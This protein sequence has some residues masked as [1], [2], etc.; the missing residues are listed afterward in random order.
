MTVAQMHFEFKL[1]LDKIDTFTNPNILPEEIDSFL[2]KAQQEF[3]EQ[4][5]YGTNPKRTGLEEDQK[6]WDDLR[7]IIKNYE[8]TTF[9]SGANN[10]DNG[11]FVSLPTD[12]RHSIEEEVKITYTDCN[13]LTATKKVPVIPIT[14]DRY[15][16]TIR[17]PFNKPDEDNILRLGYEGDVVELITDGTV[18][19]SNYY[20][21]YLK[22]PQV[23]QYGTQYVTPTADVDCELAAHTHNTYAPD[24]LRLLV[25]YLS[26]S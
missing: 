7:E 22:E 3:I 8:T 17:D 18:T 26:G 21:R 16:K 9:T 13:N 4:R 1:E 14:H 19:L 25:N 6:R 20:L 2:N 12:Y 10:K 23:I 15:N 5:A 24:H 11:S